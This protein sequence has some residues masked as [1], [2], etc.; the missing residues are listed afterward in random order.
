MPEGQPCAGDGTHQ[1][2][3][4]FC[5]DRDFH[6]ELIDRE[7]RFLHK[8]FPGGY[9]LPVRCDQGKVVRMAKPGPGS[10]HGHGIRRE[11]GKPY[12]HYT[13]PGKPCGYAAPSIEVRD[14][15]LHDRPNLMVLLIACLLPFAAGERPGGVCDILRLYI[16]WNARVHIPAVIIDVPGIDLHLLISRIQVLLPVKA[17]YPVLILLVIILHQEPDGCLLPAFHICKCGSPG[18]VAGQFQPHRGL[19]LNGCLR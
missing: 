12:T 17:L 10:I 18:Q 15:V 9:L 13:L 11:P 8:P 3:L 19:C 1:C 4:I 16:P 14:P 6:A 7:L 5:L 2:F